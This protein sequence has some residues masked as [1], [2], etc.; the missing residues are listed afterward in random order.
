MRNRK[1]TYVDFAFF[2]R[3]GIQ[4]YLEKKAL[5]GWMVKDAVG[6][7]WKFD[8]IEPKKLHFSVVYFSNEKANDSSAEE[9]REDFMAYCRHSGWELA[10]KHSSMLIWYHTAENPIPIETDPLLELETIH[11]SAK[12]EHL[13]DRNIGVFCGI[14]CLALYLAAF[15]HI[16]SRAVLENIWFYYGIYAIVKGTWNGYELLHYYTWRKRAKLAAQLDG[17][18]VET[19]SFPFVNTVLRAAMCFALLLYFAAVTNL[20]FGYVTI[21]FCVVMICTI[22]ISLLMRS[23]DSENEEDE[24][25]HAGN[26]AELSA[27]FAMFALIVIVF[28]IFIGCMAYHILQL[29]G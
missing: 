24:K 4:K 19:R 29:E 10:A 16:F 14:L 23:T 25:S 20:P 21:G 28:A 11:K 7:V 22:L 2:D 6:I 13:I 1:Y 18:F 12:K 5:Q 27:F 17:S 9:R 15:P 8:R 26:M 3:T